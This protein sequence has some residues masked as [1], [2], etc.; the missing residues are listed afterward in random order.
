[1]K[2]YRCIICGYI[3][4]EEKEGVKFSDLPDDWKC[5]L[6]GSSKDLFEEIKEEVKIN[7]TEIEDDNEKDLRSLTNSE[8][9][10]I[11]SNLKKSCDKQ[12]LEEESNLFN[13]LYIYFKSKINNED[14]NID[15]IISLYK[16]D[17]TM[18]NNAMDISSKYNDRGAKRVINWALKST[19]LVNSI[20]KT[21]KE[22]GMSYIKNS[23]IWVCDICGFIYIGETPLTVCP[24]CKVPS[25]KILEV[26]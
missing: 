26:E 25:I 21:Y 5:P 11:C 14:G 3:Y 20:I 24:I 22:K 7:T 13:E 1:M 12:Y 4:D 16:D 18:L 15:D 10:Y 23:K 2:K 19:N 9:A 6:C 17:L 8:I